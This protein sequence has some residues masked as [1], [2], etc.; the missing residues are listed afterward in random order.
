MR[1]VRRTGAS[2]SPLDRGVCVSLLGHGVYVYMSVSVHH[3]SPVGRGVYAY[4]PG[5]CSNQY[6]FLDLRGKKHVESR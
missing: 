1:T 5:T 4:M 6:P 2:T 3:V